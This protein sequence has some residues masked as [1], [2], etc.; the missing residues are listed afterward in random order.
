MEIKLNTVKIP[1]P[2]RFTIQWAIIEGTFRRRYTLEYD[3]ISPENAALILGVATAATFSIT[4]TDPAT[5]SVITRNV[6]SENLIIS[7]HQD[8]GGFLSYAPLTLVF[9]QT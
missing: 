6:L 9:R 3:L 5:N 7:L 4:C 2:H 8:A 1:E